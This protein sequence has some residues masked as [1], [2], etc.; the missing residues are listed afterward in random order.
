MS[1]QCFPSR[2]FTDR[3]Q[4]KAR[5]PDRA[6][7]YG[8]P[9][10]RAR[11][12]KTIAAASKES[13]S[14]ISARGRAHENSARRRLPL[15]FR[16]L[17]RLCTCVHPGGAR[18]KISIRRLPYSSD[19]CEDCLDWWRRRPMPRR[20]A[21]ESKRSMPDRGTW[22]SLA[23]PQP[24]C[25]LPGSAWKA[26]PRFGMAQRAG[27]FPVA[28]QMPAVQGRTPILATI[29]ASCRL[30]ISGEHLRPF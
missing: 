16:W 8:A 21:P 15:R 9:R 25:V 17:L 27:L 19:N 18:Q 11:R 12:V 10:G 5:S 4:L 29:R 1:R 6:A 23:P 26:P 24:L 2:F 20:F 30:V 7:R 3:A 22:Q 28:G 14:T 13:S